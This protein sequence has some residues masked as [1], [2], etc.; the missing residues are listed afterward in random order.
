M[1]IDPSASMQEMMESQENQG[2]LGIYSILL[3]LGAHFQDM[4]Y[5]IP[6][7]DEAMSFAEGIL[8]I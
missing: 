8:N 4:A 1:E 7:V 3:T 6:G 2:G 5:A